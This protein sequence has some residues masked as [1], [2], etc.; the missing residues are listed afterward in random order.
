MHMMGIT[1]APR[2]KNLS[3][4]TLYGFKSTKTAKD[5]FITPKKYINVELI[6]QNWDDILRFAATIKLRY[7]SSSQLFKRLNS[8][9]KQHMLYKAL[10]EFG[11][12]RKTLFILR[13]MQ[14]VRFRQAIEKQL[15][16]GE[17]S[18]KFSKAV[19]F[20]NNQEILFEEKEEQ[21]V[22]ENCRQLIK[23]AI[24]L[25][26]YLYLVKM[27]QSDDQATVQYA[28]TTLQKGN[29]LAWKHILLHGQYDMSSENTH[30]EFGLADPKIVTLIHTRFWEPQIAA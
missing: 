4:Q 19:A 10:K 26:N 14:D 8:Y 22:A 3:G 23:N 27:L 9:S 2:L 5:D 7:A 15:N 1:F 11:R 18:N 28:L 6:K 13:Y 30:D 17:N 24:I 25:W 12:L 16:R 21:E 29:V 20:G